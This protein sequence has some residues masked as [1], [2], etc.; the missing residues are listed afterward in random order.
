MAKSNLGNKTGNNLES[1]VD[2]ALRTQGYRQVE[3]SELQAYIVNEK[4]GYYARQVKLGKGIYGTG[5][6][7]DFMICRDSSKQPLIIECKWQQSG[8][9][10]DE[11]LPFLVTNIRERYPHQTCVVIDGPGFRPGAI[12]WLKQMK[13][14]KI[15]A[16]LQMQEF[17]TWVNNGGLK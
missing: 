11:K 12:T 17:Q 6:Q 2:S 13:D 15:V 8:G 9:T 7:A 5:I 1:F 16:V 10:A 4:S 14:K 3:E